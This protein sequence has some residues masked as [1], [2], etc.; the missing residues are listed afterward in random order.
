MTFKSLRKWQV[1]WVE[2]LISV[3][4]KIKHRAEKR[5]SANASSKRSDYKSN[6]NITLILLI[7]LAN[8]ILREILEIIMKI[9]HDLNFCKNEEM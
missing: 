6:E 8:L 4:F 7:K 2:F 1:H 5:N 9:C 3:I